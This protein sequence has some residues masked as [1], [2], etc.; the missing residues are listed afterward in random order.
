MDDKICWTLDE[1]KNGV[2]KGSNRWMQMISTNGLPLKP[3]PRFHQLLLLLLLWPTRWRTRYVLPKGEGRGRGETFD[4][5]Y[6]FEKILCQVAKVHHQKM[7][8]EPSIDIWRF[9]IFLFLFY[10]FEMWW[11]RGSHKT[12]LFIYS[13][14]CFKIR[15]RK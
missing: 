4:R 15:Q 10:F 6:I 12:H 9:V 14:F 1:T 8:L 13:I 11:L 7:L 2:H 3:C 5:I